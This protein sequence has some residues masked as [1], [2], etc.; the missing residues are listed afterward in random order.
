MLEITRVGKPSDMTQ[1]SLQSITLVQNQ[2]TDPG[3]QYCDRALAFFK[4]HGVSV[5]VIRVQGKD[6]PDIPE[7]ASHPDLVLVIGGDGTLLRVARSFAPS[8]VPL[9]GIHT[10]TLGFLTHIIA[11]QMD[12]YLEKLVRG[13]YG[14]ESRMMLAVHYPVPQ[15][16]QAD[17]ALALNDVVIKNA[18]PSQLCTLRFYINNSL[19]AVYDADGLILSTPTGTTAYTLSA[20]GPVISPEVEAVS[21]TPICPHSFSAKAIVVPANKSFM[22]ESDPKNQDVIFAL[23]GQESGVLKP[24]QALEVFRAPMSLKMVNFG[25]EDDDFYQLLKKK[26]QWSMNPRTK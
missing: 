16:S 21:I 3:N 10:G 20:G 18:N 9:V 15:V 17:Q 26:L 5:Q 7:S 24:G 13:E 19:V 22:V 23:D 25:T 14:L 12:T 1:R 2:S 4:S 11:E 8:Q 6:C